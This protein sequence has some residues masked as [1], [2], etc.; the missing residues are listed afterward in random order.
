MTNADNILRACHAELDFQ[1]IR[2]SGPGGQNVNKVA[3]AAQLRFDLERSTALPVDARRRLSRT[4]G[5]RLAADG[6]LTIEAKRYRTQERNRQDAL[7]RFDQ[8]ILRALEKPK[9][10][11]STKPTASSQRRRLESKKRRGAVK[12]TRQR[13]SYD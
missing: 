13:Q 8:L 6:V 9:P 1:Y 11:L 5:R 10:R 7:E 3:T 4:S 12:K 2:A